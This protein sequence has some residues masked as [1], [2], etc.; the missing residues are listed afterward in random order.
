MTRE[1]GMWRQLYAAPTSKYNLGMMMIL[2]MVTVIM[3]TLMVVM[4]CDNEDNEKLNST[5]KALFKNTFS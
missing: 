4:V 5:Q 3:M 2:V 1:R